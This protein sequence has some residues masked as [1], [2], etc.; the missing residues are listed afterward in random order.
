MDYFDLGNSNESY[1]DDLYLSAN[2]PPPDGLL[3]TVTIQLQN[4]V[5]LLLKSNLFDICVCQILLQPKATTY[6]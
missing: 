4:D 5:W 6:A 3:K 2:G 1:F